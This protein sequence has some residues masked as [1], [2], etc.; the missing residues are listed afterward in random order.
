MGPHWEAGYDAGINVHAVAPTPGATDE[1]TM[2][3]WERGAGATLACGTGATAAAH[4]AHEWGLVGNL[5][6]VH[7]PGGD[8]E[9]VVGPSMTLRGPSVRIASIEVPA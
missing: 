2:A 4:A 1:L 9:V 7:M 6:R 3:I 5:V 8:V